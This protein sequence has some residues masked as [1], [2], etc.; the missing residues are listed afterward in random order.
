MASDKCGYTRVRGWP[1]KVS[2]EVAGLA[3]Y[4]ER[5]RGTQNGSEGDDS[6]GP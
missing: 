3:A 6:R 4:W 2:R 1:E 5:R